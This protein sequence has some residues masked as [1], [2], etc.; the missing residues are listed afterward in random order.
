[1]LYIANMGLSRISVCLLIKKILPGSVASTSVM[2]F[3]G[4]TVLWTISGVFVTAFPC[5]LP[6]P[7]QFDATKKCIDIIKWINYVGITNIVVE[8]LLVAIPLTVWNLRASAGKR[9]SVSLMFLARL[10]SVLSPLI[11]SCLT[12][13]CSVVAAVSAQLY[14]F[15]HYVPASDFT[16]HYW[17]PVICYQIAQN[18]SIITANLPCLHPFII[19]V[20]AGTIKAETIAFDCGIQQYIHKKTGRGGFDAISSQS[21]SLPMTEEEYCRPLATYG[22]DRSSAHLNSQ[23]FNRFPVNI[24]TPL[25][26]AEPPENVFMKPVPVPPSRPTTSYSTKTPSR[27]NSLTRTLSR[28][29]SRSQSKKSSKSRPTSTYSSSSKPPQMPKNLAEVGCLPAI[30]WETDSSDR[31]SQ[32]SGGS[33][34]RPPSEY[35][36]KRSKVISVPEESHLEEDGWKKYYPPLPSPKFPRRPPGM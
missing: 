23:H 2:V 5:S 27:G 26:T 18:L 10:R 22:L 20:L 4:F 19:K 12:D 21:S 3:A 28:K 30:D 17:R 14:Y 33:S 8:I 31:G 1:M 7:W 29:L 24:A 9:I 34:R 13:I 6:N 16:F 11:A 15:N 35:I 25:K 36:F 32:R